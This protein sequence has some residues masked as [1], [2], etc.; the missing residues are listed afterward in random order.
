MLVVFVVSMV[1]SFG[2]NSYLFVFLEIISV[3]VRRRGGGGDGGNGDGGDFIDMSRRSTNIVNAYVSTTYAI[4]YNAYIN[5]N[6]TD[7][8]LKII[9]EQL[10]QW[11]ASR[12][13]NATL[14]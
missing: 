5:P 3:G 12:H 4:F 14:Y 10:T 7:H 9:T 8:S 11:Q 13:A 6:G 2:L 1:L